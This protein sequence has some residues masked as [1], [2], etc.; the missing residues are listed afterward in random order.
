[1]PRGQ[2]QGGH[3]SLRELRD[4]LLALGDDTKTVSLAISARS[5]LRAV[6]LLERL[7]WDSPPPSE[8]ARGGAGRPLKSNPD[9]VL[10]TFRAAATAWAAALFPAFG[11]RERFHAIKDAARMAGGAS[12]AGNSP[13]AFAAFATHQAMMVAQAMYSKRPPFP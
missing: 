12:H 11:G 2:M 1:M 3:R 8:H 13:A 6:P 5:A 10:G 4:Q 7:F 9:I